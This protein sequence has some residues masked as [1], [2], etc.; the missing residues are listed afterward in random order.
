[1]WERAPPHEILSDL[2]A[3]THANIFLSEKSME[4]L[5]LLLLICIFW[6]MIITLVKIKAPNF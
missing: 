2:H 4:I 5:G 1:M 6:L 3:T